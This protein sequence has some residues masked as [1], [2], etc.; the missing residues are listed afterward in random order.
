MDAAKAVPSF[1]DPSARKMLAPPGQEDSIW[2]L[3]PG[4]V[5]RYR[6]RVLTQFRQSRWAL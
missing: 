3:G 1:C 6:E 4:V 5:E 2:T